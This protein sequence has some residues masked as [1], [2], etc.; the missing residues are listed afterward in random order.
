MR[1]VE[2]VVDFADLCIFAEEKGIAFYNAAHDILFED[3]Y[4]PPES[5]M[6]EVYLS[7]LKN[8]PDL[9]DAKAKDIL[10]G[11]MEEKNVKFITVSRD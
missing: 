3:A 8:Y 10:V 9:F 6:R 5:N 2:N 7:E 11:F 1:N 4:P